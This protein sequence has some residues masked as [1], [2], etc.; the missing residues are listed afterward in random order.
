MK[1]ESGFIISKDKKIK[2]KKEDN[3]EDN[4]ILYI[5]NMKKVSENHIIYKNI[6]RGEVRDVVISGDRETGKTTVAL[7]MAYLETLKDNQ[8]V[9]VVALHS[10]KK[11]AKGWF[12]C[13]GWTIK[14][15]IIYNK[16]DKIVGFIADIST[17]N[18]HKNF[19]YR[20]YNITTVI[21]DELVQENRTPSV[22]LGKQMSSLTS[23][24][25]G[26]RKL[27]KWKELGIIVFFLTN[28]I[29]NN[30][31]IFTN[32]GIPDEDIVFKDYYIK[33]FKSNEKIHIRVCLMSLVSNH[34]GDEID[35]L[36]TIGDYHKSA[37]GRKL[38]MDNSILLKEEINMDEWLYVMNIKI[39]DTVASVYCNDDY[40]LINSIEKKHENNEYVV[41]M[42]NSKLD[43]INLTTL[44]K[45]RK[46]YIKDKVKFGD[47]MYKQLFINAMKMK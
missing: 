1:Q 28:N 32:Y 12:V 30:H 11:E 40:L 4:S 36:L 31:P 29:N 25:L 26:W 5:N 33:K 41:L 20:N 19:G 2:T 23:S 9:Y 47:W 3:L 27:E 10:M 7:Y 46:L 18:N 17:P 24:L 38:S 42:S 14:N 45:V 13:M 39:F 15:N 43:N 22:S 8:F 35:P 44:M 37:Y 34:D 21:Y 16:E 6:V